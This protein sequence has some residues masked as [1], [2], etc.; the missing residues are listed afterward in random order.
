MSDGRV[1]FIDFGIVGSL[2]P[3]SWQA[4]Q[5]CAPHVVICPMVQRGCFLRELRI[6]VNMRSGR[7]PLGSKPAAA[8]HSK[9]VFKP[10]TLNVAVD[11]RHWPP[12]QPSRTS[13]RL[14]GR[15]PL[16]APPGRTSTSRCS[17]SG[18]LFDKL[19]ICLVHRPRHLSLTSHTQTRKALEGGT[20][21]RGIKCS[22]LGA[23]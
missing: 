9:H 4:I 7:P 11:R 1:G 17:T 2:A 23:K 19:F 13:R 6:Q 16:W 12:R 15:W 10:C 22:C 5:V 14:P 3:A 18:T 20:N 8:T 21:S